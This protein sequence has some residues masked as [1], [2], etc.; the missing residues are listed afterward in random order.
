MRKIFLLLTFF[1]FA[2]LSF[3][4]DQVQV[5]LS[6]PPPNQ[7]RATDLWKAILINTTKST[8][9]ITLSGTLEVKG[10]GMVVNGQSGLMSLPPGTKMITYNDV[11]TGNVNFKPGSWSEAFNRTGNS[12]SGDYTI[13]IHVKAED[14]REIS[15]SCIDQTIDQPINQHDTDGVASLIVKLIP[16]PTNQLKSSDLWKIIATNVSATAYNAVLITVDLKEKTSGIQVESK[17]KS[18]MI[19]GS[20]RL[21]FSDFNLAELTYHNTKLQEAFSKNMNAPDG[22]YTICVSVKNERGEEVARDCIDQIISTIIPEK[23]SPQLI[24]PANGSKLNANQPILFTWMLPSIKSGADISY[25]LKVV[26]ILGNQSPSEAVKL[27][28]AVFEKNEIRTTMLQYPLSAKKIEKNKKYAWTVQLESREGQDAGEN[29]RTTEAFVFDVEGQNGRTKS[30]TISN[31]AD[32]ST[33]GGGTGTVAVNDTIKAGHNGEFKVIVTDVTTES[34]SSVTGKGRVHIN[35][36]GT[37]VAVEFKK[38]RVDTTKRLTSGG[39]VTTESGSSSTSYLAYPLAWAESVLTG[40]GAANVVDHIVNW[41]NGKIDNLVTWVNSLNYGQP[42]INYQSNIPPPVLPDYTLKMPF[43]L[44]FNNGNQKLVITEMVFKK[45]SSKINFLVQEKFTKS[46]T[47]YTLGFAGKYFPVHPSSINFTSGRVELAEDIKIPNTSA[48]PKMIFNFRKGTPNS[49][50]YVEWDSTGVKDISLALDVKFT[51]DWLLPV[52]T[53]TDSVKATITGNGTSMQDILLTGTLDSC[54]IVG[55]N[56]IKILAGPMSLDLS[57]SRNPLDMN[58]PTNYA[59]DST[60]AWK[61]FYVKIFDVTLPDTW[62][63]GTNLTAPVVS[64]Y[65]FIIDDFGLTT[66]IKAVNVFNLQSGRIADLS[67]SLD[68]VEI[69]IISSS[70]VSGK[71]K[72]ILVLPISEVTTQNSLKYTAT[73]NQ[74]S[75]G[76]NFQIAIL[77]V[78]PIDADIFKGKM[79][80]LPTSNISAN[81]SPNSNTLSINLNGTFKWDNPN[82]PIKGIKMELGFENVGLNYAYNSTTN[83]LSFN[84]G[85]WSFASPPKWLANF[86]VSI[87][88]IYYKS[89]S[90]ASLPS[91]NMELLRGALMIDLVANLTEDIGG[92]TTLGASFAVELNK[93]DKKFTPKFKEVFLDSISVHAD[94]PAVKIDGNLS[95]RNEDPVYGNG[96]LGE[97]TVVFTS[98]GLKAKALVEF[99]NTN[100][101]YGSLYRYWR[102]EADIL[103]P[104]PGVPFLTGLAFRGFGGGAYYN[105][106]ATQATSAKTPSGKKFTF[107]PLKSTMGLRVAATIA[108]T[109][110]EE[111]FNADVGLLAQFSKSQGLTYI[112][113]TG[114]F[115]VGAGF[116]KRP[117]A[118]ISGT[119]NVS[120]DFPDK[121]FNLSASVNVNAP[122]I[123]TPSPS[124]LVLDIRGKTNKWFFKFGEPVPNGLNNVDVF[125]VHLYEYLMF[126][127]DIVAPSGFTQ[128]FKDGYHGVFGIDPGIPVIPANT[129]TATGKGF[130]LGIGFKFNKDVNF[131]LVGSYSAELKLNAGAELNLAFAEYNGNNCEYPSERI[132]IN[133]WQAS[134]SIGFYASVLAS[135]K[136]GSSTWNIADI[137]A[138][139]WLQGKFPNPV[140]VTGL[141]EGSVKIGHFTTWTHSTGDWYYNS[142]TDFGWS[143]CVHLQDHYLVNTSFNKSFEYGTNCSGITSAGDGATVVQGDAAEDQKQLLVQYVHPAQQYSFPLISPLAVQYGLIPNNVF[144]VSEQQSDGSIK[145]RTF[146][147]VVIT[148]LKIHN[149]DGSLSNVVLKKNENNLG[150]YLYTVSTPN[151]INTTTAKTISQTQ[152]KI[153]TNILLNNTVIKNTASSGQIITTTY[154]LPPASNT[155]NNLPPEA[156]EIKNNLTIDKDYTFTVTATLKEFVNNSW[157]NAKNKNNN[158]I[159]QSVTKNFR[160]G[161]MVTVAST[162][163]SKNTLINK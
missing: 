148:N 23:V 72:G 40:P 21:S 158:V 144:D 145:N 46:G 87:K 89:L 79:T 139:G 68:T 58:F 18:V 51:R 53:S 152:T 92:A 101:L 106:L 12:P 135:V 113:F 122:P 41:S 57:D 34:D 69:S 20:K 8:I 33:S 149:A 112:A 32:S 30:L 50:C 124:N 83:T 6:Q 110:K 95:I 37:N 96:F 78:G 141:V 70:L 59:N 35:W 11:K 98:V 82:F 16:P 151:T 15:S 154:P 99:G 17:L 19:S 90:K 61:G 47:P 114:D 159:T 109:P 66:K 91:P 45:D 100:Y 125:G 157:I 134:G 1:F 146:K 155:Y 97:L 123:T 28:P 111:T 42:Q 80:L 64:A 29:S 27:N 2:G 88:K 10:E 56:G 137:K 107:T 86:P 71:A 126:G 130:A 85:S 93:T 84:P 142:V 31:P 105:M 119:V 127:N 7:L 150:E 39:I 4:Q 131:N 116:A 49:G 44:Q 153:N 24:S 128:T 104:P 77:P 55:T 54:E 129:L 117:K 102:V 22:N 75:G 163:N 115:W 108:T 147:I 73:F 162:L 161:P 160:T 62:K 118:N 3:A 38:I 103:L 74:V 81:L 25:S 67:A 138:G 136:K 76:N 133:G 121:H 5:K 13:C 48:N 120:Y 63:T 43:G 156:P 9:H 26:E 14:G 52:P 65:N 94:M 140:Y 60:A 36:L 132:G 143:A